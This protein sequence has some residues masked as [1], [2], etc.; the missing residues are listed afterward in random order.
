MYKEKEERARLLI[1]KLEALK[2]MQ[3][4]RESLLKFRGYAG[5]KTVLNDIPK[6]CQEGEAHYVL[7]SE[8]QLAQRMPEFARIFVARK[9]RKRLRARIL[10]RP[11]RL[12]GV[13]SHLARVRYLPQ[14]TPS[15]SV[16]NIHGRKVAIIFWGDVPEAVIID[17]AATAA[18]YR[19][20]FEFMWRHA[21]R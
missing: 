11:G 6:T 14:D 16:T 8:G 4:S 1:P 20:Y 9:D 5:V 18:T 2:H 7:G 13:R 15:L 10:I 19:G 3:A 17:D 12:G 21:R